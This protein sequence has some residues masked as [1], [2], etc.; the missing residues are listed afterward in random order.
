MSDMSYMF[1]VL[2]E[3]RKA[4]RRA[5]GVNCPRCALKRPHTNASLLLPNQRCKVDNYTDPRKA[6][7]AEAIHITL[8]ADMQY[9]LVL[10]STD[11]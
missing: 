11:D 5:F 7:T 10:L 1:N 2:R 4:L 3:R 8:R 6:L 9:Q